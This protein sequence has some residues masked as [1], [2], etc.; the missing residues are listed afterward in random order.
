MK[1]GDRIGV[2]GPKGAFIYSP[3]MVKEIGMVAG[4]TGITPMLQIIKAILRNPADKTKISLIFGNVTKSDI[5]LEEELQGLAEQHP[6]RF[7]VYH[8]LNEPP[9]NWN[10]GVGF[11]TKDILEQRLPKPSNDVK[12]LVCGPPPMVKAVTNVNG[13]NMGYTCIH[14]LYR[15][16]RI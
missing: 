6:D 2:R 16:Q 14:S 10:Q 11:I 7:S 8:V 4:G 15:L 13:L 5:L 1:V 12:I 9:E 3:N